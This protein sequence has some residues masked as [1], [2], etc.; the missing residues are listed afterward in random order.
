MW[1]VPRTGI[2]PAA[3][4]RGDVRAGGTA[5]GGELLGLLG[6]AHTT[7]GRWGVGAGAGGR[8]EVTVCDGCH[9]LCVTGVTVCAARVSR[10]VRHGCHGLC[11]RSVAGMHLNGDGFI[12][13]RSRRWRRG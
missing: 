13:G 4:P 2:W 10:P 7:Q 8:D 11:V 9:G 1:A 6:P 12:G 5:G 3:V